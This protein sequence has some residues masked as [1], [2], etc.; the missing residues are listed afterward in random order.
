V[1][2]LFVAVDLPPAERQAVAALCTGLER[3]RWVKTSQLHITLRFLGATPEERLSDLRQRLA[4]VRVAPF[5]LALHGVGVFPPGGR[6][7]RV[8]WLGLVPERP[9]RELEGAV[10]RALAAPD[11]PYHQEPK[12]DFNPHLTLARLAGKVDPELPSFL[13]QHA[14][15]HGR[16]WQ[17]ASFHLYKSTLGPAGSVHQI[18]ETYPLVPNC[19]ES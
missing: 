18:L 9:L 13:M 5:N 16:D 7:P 17:V 3:V 2:R 15:H 8:L 19:R 4:A 10:E 11:M 14:E 12:R 6:R 1:L